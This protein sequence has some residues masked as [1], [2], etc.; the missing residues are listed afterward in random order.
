MPCLDEAIT[1]KALP[2]QALPS[3]HDSSESSNK[4]K[5]D[6]LFNI[7]KWPIEVKLQNIENH[8]KIAKL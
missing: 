6:N 8:L 5:F 7:M 4:N 1:M 2:A 3:R